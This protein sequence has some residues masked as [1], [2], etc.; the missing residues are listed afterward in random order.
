LA[1]IAVFMLAAATWLLG[2]IPEHRVDRDAEL[3]R[4]L[5]EISQLRRDRIEWLLH[6][7]IADSCNAPLAGELTRLL[8][9]DGRAEIAR[10]FARSYLATCGDDT[11]VAK[12][13]HAPAQ[14]RR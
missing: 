10:A 2:M 8:A 14:H 3:R 12:W 11:V 13:A 5:A 9:Q 7:P 4:E 1:V 6:Q